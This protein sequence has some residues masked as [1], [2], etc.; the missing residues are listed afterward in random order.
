[1]VKVIIRVYTVVEPSTTH[2][3]HKVSCDRQIQY[4]HGWSIEEVGTGEVNGGNMDV[5]VEVDL[6]SHRPSD[7]HG[8][9]QRSAPT[10]SFSSERRAD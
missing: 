2:Q 9:T 5:D 4:F 8:R 7:S 6:D 1:M 3:I 10:R